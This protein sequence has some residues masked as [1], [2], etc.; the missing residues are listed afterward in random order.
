MGKSVAT[1]I[2]ELAAVDPTLLSD[3]ELH[4][5][6]IDATREASRFA[7]ARARLVA[8]WDARRTWADDG[9]KAAPARLARECS[10]S[11]MTARAEVRRGRK[12]RSMHCTSVALAEGKISID[13]ADLLAY[14][15]QPDVAHLFARDEQMLV[16]NVLTLRFFEA[17]QFVK[18][19]L[20]EAQD[21]IG[22]TPASCR[23]DGRHFTAVR[24]LNDTV[25]LRGSL[26]AITGTEFLGE[27]LRLEQELFEADWARA[28]ADN[29]P[30][31]IPEDLPRT[32][33]QRRA[34]ALVEMARRS[35]AMV[36]GSQYPRPL[37]TVL[38]G[39]GSFSRMCELADGTIVSPSQV[40]PLLGD[41]DIERIVFDGPSRVIDVGVRRRFFTGALRRA[42]EVRDR[43]CQ[44]PSGC[45]VPA[46]QCHIDHIEPYS[47][48]GLTVQGNGRCL[49]PVHNHQRVG[50]H[51]ERPP[52]DDDG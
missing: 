39:Y 29:G 15:N 16:D 5:L 3:T 1:A 23:H 49:C 48:G 28:R 9:S 11:T 47:E 20:Q 36:P 24:T 46:A 44:H 35:R 41:A 34:D 32:A 33:P 50:E 17:V 26:D 45:D 27:L 51:A 2:D 18:Y 14:A 37:F 13:Q 4:E 25:D 40:V 22:K 6:V 21:E 31:A 38:C 30:N 19:W 7:A 8:A 42:I 10:M 12:L 43:Y 52:P